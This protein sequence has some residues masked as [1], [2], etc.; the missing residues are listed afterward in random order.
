M[1]EAERI[2]AIDQDSPVAG[3]HAPFLKVL[4]EFGADYATS[5]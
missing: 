1:P 2:V 4:G 5:L 3:R